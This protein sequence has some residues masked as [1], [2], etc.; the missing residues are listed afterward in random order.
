[1]RDTQ[2]KF[3]DAL[4]GIAHQNDYELVNDRRYGNTG[5]FRVQKAS[6]FDSV[7]TLSYSFQDGYVTFYEITPEELR[8]RADTKGFPHV[9]PEE[10]E[11]RVLDR[12]RKYLAAKRWEEAGASVARIIAKS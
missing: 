7:L 5:T 10:L 1:M 8:D 3:T 12:I 4:N 9:T 11:V 6:S 2:E